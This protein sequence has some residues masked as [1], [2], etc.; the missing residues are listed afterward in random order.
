[1][2]TFSTQLKKFRQERHLS[3]AELAK[4]LFISRQAISK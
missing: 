4:D 2:T 3:Q 1:M